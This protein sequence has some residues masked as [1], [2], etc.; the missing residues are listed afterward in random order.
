MKTTQS[1]LGE[2][3]KQ[4]Q[5]G[6]EEGREGGT[7]EG[8][9]MGYGINGGEGKPDLVLGEEKKGLKP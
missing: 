1:H 7:R 8:K 6:G 9:W 4:S 2:K 3:R 5:V